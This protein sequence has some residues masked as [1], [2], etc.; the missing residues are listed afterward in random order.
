[1]D[2]YAIAQVLFSL[3]TSLWLLYTARILGGILSLATLLKHHSTENILFH[4]EGYS[5][6][7]GVQTRPPPVVGYVTG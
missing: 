3:A 5:S 6:V 2:C 4:G 1:L 7:A